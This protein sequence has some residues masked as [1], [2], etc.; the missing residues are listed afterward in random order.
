M[1]PN[2]VPSINNNE[3]NLFMLVLA[4][5]F[6][7]TANAQMI[8]V[9]ELE[10]KAC[11]EYGLDPKKPKWEEKAKELVAKGTVALDKNNSI[12]W[13]EVIDCGEAS[14]SQLYVIL[15]YWFTQTF[16]D[17]NSVIK[18][19]DKE[20]GTIIGQGYLEGIASHT[21]GSNSY[22]VSVKPTIKADI[23]D[24]KV[25]IT[26]TIQAFEVAKVAGGGILGT[27]TNS[28]T[29]KS[30]ANWPIDKTYPFV[31]KP[32]NEYKAPKS[33]SKGL[34]MASTYSEVLMDKIKKALQEGIDGNENDAW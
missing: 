4:I 3:K 9:E 33:T 20:L 34:I 13:S 28:K 31:E 1:Q 2:I 17:A 15:N 5:F 25:R 18:L 26:Y 10:E 6:I 29:S 24:K 12:T 23:K 14:K 16:N 27:L 22:R 30:V 21:G 7:N 32:E 11:N 8:R 19:N